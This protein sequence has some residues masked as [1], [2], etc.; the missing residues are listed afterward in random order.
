[1]ILLRAPQFGLG[2][3]LNGFNKTC[4]GRYIMGEP[5]VFINSVPIPIATL[6]HISF[7]NRQI[8]TNLQ[9]P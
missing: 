8:G 5:Q 2:K 7:P 9:E 6:A 4:I 1:M 3:A